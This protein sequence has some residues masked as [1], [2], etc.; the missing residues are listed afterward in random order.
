M[1]FEG[2]L[3]FVSLIHVE[4]IRALRVLEDVKAMCSALL[5]HRFL[6]I[7]LKELDKLLPLAC[8]GLDAEQDREY[9]ALALIRH[10]PPSV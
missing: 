2:C 10:H 7:P 9:R 6:P 1:F 4:V 5:L 3:V 8:L